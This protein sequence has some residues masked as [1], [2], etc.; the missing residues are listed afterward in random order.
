M[1]NFNRAYSA[2]RSYDLRA[3]YNVPM[4]EIQELRVVRP[5]SISSYQRNTVVEGF[6]RDKTKKFPQ[7]FPEQNPAEEYI[8]AVRDPCSGQYCF[9]KVGREQPFFAELQLERLYKKDTR[10]K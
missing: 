6:A 9:V 2:P 4:G 8:R 3:P 1:S 7:G 5:F 10:V